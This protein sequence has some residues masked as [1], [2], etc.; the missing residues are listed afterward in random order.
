MKYL[1]PIL[2]LFS[3][4]STTK[5]IKSVN[6][7]YVDS[8]SV[9]RVDSSVNTKID[10]SAVKKDN[11]VTIKEVD[12]NYTK[13]TVIEF[14]TFRISQID[15]ADYFPPVK[16]IKITETG[17]KKEKI[18]T[19]ANTSDSNRKI[20]TGSTDLTKTVK[21]ELVKT[22]TV[23]NVDIKRTSYWGWLWLIPLLI[24]AVIIYRYR[25]E[26]SFFIKRFI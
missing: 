19:K 21:T 22:Q 24:L 3:S 17:F 26:I 13:E 6:R 7:S 9:T 14:D 1:I 16:R 4:C 12:S 20:I 8:S 23:K 15:A 18:E 2:L 10:S 11:T 25:K 5:K